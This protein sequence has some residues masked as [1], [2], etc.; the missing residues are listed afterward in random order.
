MNF[1]K[2]MLFFAIAGNSYAA[3]LCQTYQVGSFHKDILNY[4]PK[5]NFNKECISYGMNSMLSLKVTMAQCQDKNGKPVEQALPPC[6]DDNSYLDVTYQSIQV[7]AECMDISIKE[8]LPKIK[9]ESGF[10][11]NALGRDFDAGI[12]QLTGNAIK[13]AQ[14]EMDGMKKW[15]ESRA[16]TNPACKILLS[17]W[18]ALSSVTSTGINNRCE[19]LSWPLNPLKNIFW[20]GVFLKRLKNLTDSEMTARDIKNKMIQAGLKESD[21]PNMLGLIENLSYNSGSRSA[22]VHLNNYLDEKNKR[23]LQVTIQDFN[24]KE[25]LYNVT[26]DFPFNEMSFPAY[27]K[28]HMGSGYLSGMMKQIYDYNN[29]VG[30]HQCSPE[31]IEGFLAL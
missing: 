30:P 28:T 31:Y 22:V 27:I 5:S 14:G 17:K 11:H 6:L 7:V 21:Y 15:M 25:N 18:S 9:G 2:A 23:G 20:T 10:L 29:N 3:N 16:E 1:I 13:D 19:L 12:G 4:Q 26:K 8:I 24:F